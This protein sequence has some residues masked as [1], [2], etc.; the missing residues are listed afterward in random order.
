MGVTY[1]NPYLYAGFS[2]LQLPNLKLWVDADDAATFTYSSGTSVSQWNDKSGNGYHLVQSSSSAQP[3]R[4]GTLN[5]KS[6]VVFDGL[7]DALSV[8]NFDMTGSQTVS[9]AI[10]ATAAT[11]N[12]RMF[13][14]HGLNQPAGGFGFYRESA[15]NQVTFYRQGAGGANGAFFKSDRQLTTTARIAVATGDGTLSTDENTVWIDG[16]GVGTRAPNN[17]TNANNISATLYVGS[18]GGASLYMS[19][20]IAELI[21]TR[22]VLTTD[23]RI[24]VQNYLAAKWGIT[25]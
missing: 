15:G 16:N 20:I 1:I 17:N 14:E 13:A 8:A 19:G 9:A 18:R 6:T 22:S 25:I 11:G 12:F 5:G 4:S 10:V 24:S 2:P 7:N 23:E 3:S 21:I